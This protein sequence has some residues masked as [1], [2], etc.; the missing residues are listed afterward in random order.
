MLT[1]IDLSLLFVTSHFYFVLV[2]E[3]KWDHLESL[4]CWNFAG[5]VVQWSLYILLSLWSQWL[6]PAVFQ[7]LLAHLLGHG[8]QQHWASASILA[9][10]AVR[11]L[12]I[13]NC[14]SRRVAVQKLHH[15]SLVLFRLTL[16][17]L[18][19]QKLAESSPWRA[20]C[21]Y[22]AEPIRENR[23]FLCSPGSLGA[24]T[25]PPGIPA[26]PPASSLGC[27]GRW[28]AAHNP[29]WPSQGL[30]LSQSSASWTLDCQK[31]YL[32]HWFIE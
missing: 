22:L 25:C 6:P 29:T 21:L 26:S 16:S 7:G 13:I 4:C 9:S 15:S 19:H 28:K 3:S 12:Q 23:E 30:L 11:V 8:W 20:C 31:S 1:Y 24:H 14:P 17:N 27:W 32:L 10:T 2:T 5:R 18:T